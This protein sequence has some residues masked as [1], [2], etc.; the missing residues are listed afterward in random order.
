MNLAHVRAIIVVLLVVGAGFVVSHGLQSKRAMVPAPVDFK[1]YIYQS[2]KRP[3][4]VLQLPADS[5]MDPALIKKQFLTLFRAKQ[6]QGGPDADLQNLCL[7]FFH[8][9]SKA[10]EQQAT[11]I[12]TQINQS[13]NVKVEAPAGAL[14]L[15]QAKERAARVEELAMQLYTE[16]GQSRSRVEELEHM[17][18]KMRTEL[19]CMEQRARCAPHQDGSELLG[20]REVFEK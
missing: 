19:T 16:L 18:L 3:Y 12:N 5:Q 9:M 10:Q 11:T 6:E 8:L 2:F 7:A 13:F 14:R 20:M 15:A 4:E 1:T 17:S